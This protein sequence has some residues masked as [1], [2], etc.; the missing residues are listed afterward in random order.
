MAW[1]VRFDDAFEGE[2]EALETEVQDALLASAKLLA[3]YGPRLARPMRI[4]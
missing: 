2:F 4:R 1:T 3:D